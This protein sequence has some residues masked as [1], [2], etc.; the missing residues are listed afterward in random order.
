MNQKELETIWAIRKAMGN[1]STQ[2]VTES[3]IEN[4]VKTK[5][6]EEFIEDMRKKV[7][8]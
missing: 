6:N 5:S 2:E 1:A 8:L 3:F 4:L 7:W